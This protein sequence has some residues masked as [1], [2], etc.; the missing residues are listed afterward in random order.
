ME[1]EGESLGSKE[2]EGE[3]WGLGFSDS[4]LIVGSVRDEEGGDLF[5]KIK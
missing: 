4:H 2:R 1:R 5:S 3:L